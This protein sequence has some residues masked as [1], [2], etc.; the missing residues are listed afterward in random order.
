MNLI[1]YNIMC[2]LYTDI[3]QLEQAYDALIRV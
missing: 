1:L 2:T 3:R